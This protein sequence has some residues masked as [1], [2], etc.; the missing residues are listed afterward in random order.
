VQS[1]HEKY[2]IIQFKLAFYALDAQTL[3][4][5]ISIL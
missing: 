5:V 2:V 4:Y 3:G 1:E